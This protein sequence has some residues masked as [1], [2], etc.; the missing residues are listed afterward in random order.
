MKLSRRNFIG[1][2][3]VSVAAGALAAGGGKSCFRVAIMSDNQ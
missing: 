1:M 3:G 2:A